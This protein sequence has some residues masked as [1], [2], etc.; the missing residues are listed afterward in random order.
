MSRSF[1]FPTPEEVLQ[2]AAGVVG[3]EDLFQAELLPQFA[4]HDQSDQ[5]F[6]NQVPALITGAVFHQI[7]RNLYVT[8]NPGKTDF[9]YNWLYG[10]TRKKGRG[11]C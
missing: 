5:F 10:G 6:E 7:E 4:H 1:C 9:K 2:I 8:N 11:N 3:L